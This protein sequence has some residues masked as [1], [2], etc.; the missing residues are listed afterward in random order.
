MEFYKEKKII[1]TFV[2]SEEHILTIHIKQ[3][4]V[5]PVL[6]MSRLSRPEKTDV[7]TNQKNDHIVSE[8]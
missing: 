7:L 2:F 3:S 4:Y 1:S 8:K 6:I 5:I